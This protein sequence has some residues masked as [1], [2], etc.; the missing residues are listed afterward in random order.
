M[1][2]KQHT[3]HSQKRH[4]RKLTPHMDYDKLADNPDDYQDYCPRGCY[5][6]TQ[7]ILIKRVMRADKLGDRW[8]TSLSKAYRCER[9]GHVYFSR[10]WKK[11]DGQMS[12]LDMVKVQ[13]EK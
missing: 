6:H 9:C 2:K 1:P 3:T 7:Q 4:T 8:G 11:T 12:F 10:A 13:G 5:A